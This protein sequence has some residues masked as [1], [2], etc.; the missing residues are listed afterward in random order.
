MPVHT[1]LEVGL[2][3]VVLSFACLRGSKSTT[4][5]IMDCSE[6]LIYN[7]L[8]RL[9]TELQTATKGGSGHG[10]SWRVWMVKGADM[11]CQAFGKLL[12]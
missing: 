12:D 6:Y 2:T 5:D 7:L 4:G 1:M 11:V 3:E 8:A 10:L 9:L